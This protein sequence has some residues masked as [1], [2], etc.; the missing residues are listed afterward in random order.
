MT[1]PRE[2]DAEA[3]VSASTKEDEVVEWN[4][5]SNF[6]R[7]RRTI[8]HILALKRKVS[9][10]ELLK[11]AEKAIWR[12]VQSEMFNEDLKAIKSS[13]ELPAS[14]KI[15]SIL[16]FIDEEGL[17]R[18]KGRLNKSNLS[19][20]AKHPIILP[21]KHRA[22]ELFLNWQHRLNHHE[23]VEY[24]RSVI[25]REYWILGLRNALRSVKHNCVQCRRF[26]NALLPQMSDLPKDRV[27]DNV[28]PFTNCV[29][30]SLAPI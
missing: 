30:D 21:S 2:I 22:V 26:G 1:N 27:K 24:L 13:K 18:A 3:F 12:A 23:G 19:F 16:P 4:R 25:Q 29:V 15:A 28:R 14:S 10:T 6:Q 9:V 17:L 5:F 11:D 7:L 8:A 20:E